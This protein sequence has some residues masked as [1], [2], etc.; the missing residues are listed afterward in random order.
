[1]RT[2]L[3]N[4]P[5]QQAL[6]ALNLSNGNTAF[7]TNVGHGGFGDGGYM[8]MGPQPVVKNLPTGQEVAYVVMRGSPC[9]PSSSCDGRW[10]ARLG[11]MMLDST[12]VSGYQAGDVRFMQN[13]F[14]PTDEQ[15]NLTVANNYIFGGHWMFGLAHEILDRS[16]SRGTSASPI[17]TSNLSHITTSASNCGFSA[18]HYCAN[19]LIQDGDA[20][21][22]PRGFYIYYNAGTVYNQYWSEY[23]AWVVSNSQIYFV[24]TDGAVVALESGA[25]AVNVNLVPEA[26][27]INRAAPKSLGRDARPSVIS[28]L[29]A[30]EYVGQTKIVE[31]TIRYVFNNG[32]AVYLGFKHPHQGVFK[33]RILKEHWAAFSTPP[34]KLYQV[35]Q[36]VRVLGELGWYQGDPVIYVQTPAQIEIM[37]R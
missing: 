19:S 23:A 4:R 36:T 5:D 35:G 14:F 20:R 17:T 16:A 12:T 1:M 34:E 32:V 30:R 11:E 9:I 7:A 33:V 10:D 29:Q 13:T 27:E 25:P 15:A 8:P 31:G 2:N 37:H 22:L 28:Y 24:S 3:T 6:F 21:A 26:A 18:S